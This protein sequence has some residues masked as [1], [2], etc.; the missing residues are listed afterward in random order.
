MSKSLSRRKRQKAKKVQERYKSFTEEDWF[1]Y[2]T[3]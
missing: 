3:I 1:L 2:I